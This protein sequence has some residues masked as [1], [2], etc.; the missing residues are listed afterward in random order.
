MTKHSPDLI[1][2]FSD[3]VWQQAFTLIMHTL[4]LFLTH[5]GLYVPPMMWR[6]LYDFSPDSVCLVLASDQYDEEDY[7]RDYQEFID[8]VQTSQRNRSI[9]FRF[10]SDLPGK[11]TLF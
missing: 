8:A 1:I 2:S 6:E 11:F 10:M 7:Y 4:A 9:I 5:I 3:S